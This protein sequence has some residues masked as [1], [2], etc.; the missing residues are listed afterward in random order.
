MGIYVYTMRKDSVVVDGIHIGRFGFAYKMGRDWQPGGQTTDYV[1]DRD[2]YYKRKMNRTVCLKEA[3][4]ARARDALPHIRY[5]TACDKFSDIGEKPYPIYKVHTDSTY[6]VEEA[7][8]VG[9]IW[10]NGKDLM[11]SIDPERDAAVR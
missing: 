8:C 2:G 7:E 6:F 10:R 9:H 11:I 4:A 1:K 3:H 5:I